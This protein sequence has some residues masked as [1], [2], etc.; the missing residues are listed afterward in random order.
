MFRPIAQLNRQ[1]TV[2]HDRRRHGRASTSTTVTDL[3]G[4][5]SPRL[6]LD[7]ST[8][9]SPLDSGVYKDHTNLDKG[10]IA[11]VYSKI[12][13][14]I[15]SMILSVT[16]VTWRRLLPATVEFPMLLLGIAPGAN[17]VS[18]RVEFFHRIGCHHAGGANWVL[19]NRLIYNIRVVNMSLHRRSRFDGRSD[20]C[21]A[22]VNA[23]VVA[24]VQPATT[25]R[26]PL[27]NC[28]DRSLSGNEPSAIT[29]GAANS[30]NSDNRGDDTVTTYSSR[31]PTR[32]F[33]TDTNGV[34]HYD[35]LMKP[36]LVAPGNRLSGSITGKLFRLL[37]PN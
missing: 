11:V 10:N 20:L 22:L 2:S 30:F 33:S 35:H 29:V 17:L 5:L 1:V 13:P 25:A 4:C 6:F 26:T 19:A 7:G 24:A 23:G 15:G 16:E 9:S 36:D 37:I 31:G 8:A 12:S 3:S 28:M 21:R 34:K 14:R 27:V 32:S 18:A